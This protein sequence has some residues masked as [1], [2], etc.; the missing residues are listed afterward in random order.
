LAAQ[1]DT[2]VAE[3]ANSPSFAYRPGVDVARPYALLV[4][5]IAFCEAENGRGVAVHQ[6]LRDSVIAIAADTTHRSDLH[7][8]RAV[9]DG[10]A[11]DSLLQCATAPAMQRR[12]IA[13]AREG[14]RLGLS[15]SPALIVGTRL[16]LGAPSSANELRA[17]LARR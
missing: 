13:M 7:L 11:T 3:D 2:V 10:A 5:A 4:F 6:R 14:D 9:K 12:L 16:L 8:A 1:I 17:L 15:Q